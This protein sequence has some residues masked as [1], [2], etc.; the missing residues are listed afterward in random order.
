MRLRVLAI[1]IVAALAYFVVQDK[2]T[3]SA[4]LDSAALIRNIRDQSSPFRFTLHTD[5]EPPSYDSPIVLRVHVTDAAGRPA[6]GLAVE[7]TV[8][9]SGM[10]HGAQH[11]ILHGKGN[12]VYESKVKV[13]TAGSWNVD[14]TATK[15]TGN[16]S[17]SERLNMEVVVPQEN[18]Q[19]RNPNEDDSQ[20]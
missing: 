20:S 7:A 16:S 11:T 3:L 12:G 17:S 14:V 2:S 5:P 8:S 9:M 18:R 1:A 10:D 15:K 4:P 19:P 6:D 13:E